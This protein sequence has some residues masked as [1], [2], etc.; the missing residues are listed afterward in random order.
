METVEYYVVYMVVVNLEEVLVIGS[1]ERGALLVR[2][3][4]PE[5]HLS[6]GHGFL[7]L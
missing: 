1:H 7:A 2:D 6:Q 4:P 5:S 3:I